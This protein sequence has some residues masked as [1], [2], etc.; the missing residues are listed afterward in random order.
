MS[1]TNRECLLC[2]TGYYYCNNCSSDK[3]KPTWLISFCSEKCKDI[4]KTAMDVSYDSIS[5][6]EAFK[7]LSKYTIEDYENQ[8]SEVLS[9]IFLR[10]IQPNLMK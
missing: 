1:I 7:I 10:I 6:D 5:K 9:K 3:S 8:V 2:G 4:Y